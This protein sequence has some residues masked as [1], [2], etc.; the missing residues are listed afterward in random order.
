MV[1]LMLLSVVIHFQSNFNNVPGHIERFNDLA[2]H[3]NTSTMLQNDVQ[4]ILKMLY[5]RKHTH[6]I[7]IL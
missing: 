2:Q 4:F 3:Q 6:L 7:I 1:Q 5:G